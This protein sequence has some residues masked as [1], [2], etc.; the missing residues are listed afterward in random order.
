MPIR[1]RPPRR[2]R[3]VQLLLLAGAGLFLAGC[4]EDAPQ[5]TWQPAGPNAQQIDNLQRPVFYLA[6]V[7]GLIVFAAVIY[8]VWRY[9]D[10]GQAIP[11]QS[12]GKSIIEI[13]GIVASASI[14]AVI[15]VP[16]VRTIF[17]LADT[18][19][20]SLTVNVTGQQWWWE[21]SYPVQEG[22]ETPVVTSG[23]LVIPTGECVLLRITSRDVIHSYWI[24]KL[25][26]KKDAVPGRIQTLRL[27]A[28]FPGIFAGQ[29]TE[30][31]GL[32]HANMKMFAVALDGP[33]FATWLAN[34]TEPAANPPEDS[35]DAAGQGVFVAQCVRCHQVNGLEDA[36]GNPLISQ[37]EDDLVAGAAP[38]L[39]HLMSRTTFAGST[40]SLL[41]D[42][43]RAVL[44]AA[45]PEEFGPLYL[46]GVSPECLNRVELEAWVRNAPAMLPQYPT[47]NADGLGRGMP[48]LGLSEE[49]IDRVV[50][51]LATL[52]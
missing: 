27:E 40:F 31:C 14:L 48:Y 50:D 28:D 23:E 29:C 32:S 6:G 30:F 34:Q 37:A 42:E 33:D 13:G 22:I 35:P 26:G 4:A 3:A 52:Q 43:C 46:D 5:D 15:A 49:D 24:P 38:D 44:L 2:R 39:T 17:D 47:P 25:N 19:D 16:T 41:T 12:H 45:S 1:S 11:T 36:D 10:R 9:R 51:Y 7:V 21:Y 8:V 20:C 18:S